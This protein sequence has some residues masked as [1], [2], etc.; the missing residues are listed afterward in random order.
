MI[1]E[2]SIICGDCLEVM[3]DWY[4]CVDE[5]LVDL[6]LT[7]PPWPEAMWWKDAEQ[8]FLRAGPLMSELSTRIVVVLGCDTP[9]A[10]L[11]TIHKPYLRTAWLRYARPHYKGRILYSGDVA[12]AFGPAPKVS[13]GQFL[14]PGECTKTATNGDEKILEHPC[15]RPIEHF[16]WLIKHFSRKSEIVLDPFCGSGTTCVAAKMLGRRFIG[17]D[18]SEKYCEIARQRL[19]A[20]DTGVP[21]REQRKG[22]QPLFPVKNK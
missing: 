7:D 2:N 6:I 3:K 15:V 18:I 11:H 1:P 16:L 12:Y 4:N 8:L 10:M 14:I 22:Q 9:P 20:V 13:E 17:I 5:N 21:V 19:E